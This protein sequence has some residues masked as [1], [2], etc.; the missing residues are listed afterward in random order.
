LEKHTISNFRAE[1]V[2]LGSKRIY[3]W[4]EKEKAEGVG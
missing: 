4:L 3:V 1:V 2:M